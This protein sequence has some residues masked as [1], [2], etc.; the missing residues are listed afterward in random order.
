MR[1]LQNSHFLSENMFSQYIPKNIFI[2]TIR[3]FERS[4]ALYPKF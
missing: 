1:L 3:T 4:K 2:D